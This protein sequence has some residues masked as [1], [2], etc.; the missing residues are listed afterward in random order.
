MSQ[1]HSSLHTT[2]L[3]PAITLLLDQHNETRTQFD[4]IET[5]LAALTSDPALLIRLQQAWQQCYQ[6]LLHH[7]A[8]EEYALFP[9]ISQY[10]PMV[11]M[12]IEHDDLL[13]MQHRLS[14]VL[15]AATP[16]TLDARMTAITGAWEAFSKQLMAHMV[17]EERGIFPLVTEFCEPEE[18]AMIER[19]LRE[20]N[21]QPLQRQLPVPEGVLT[22]NALHVGP[23]PH[24]TQAISLNALVD[25]EHVQVQQVFLK[26]GQ[27][28]KHH[29]AAEH[30]TLWVLSGELYVQVDGPIVNK[31][32][33]TVTDLSEASTAMLHQ[34]D[35]LSLAP[36]TWSQWT[37]LSDV[38]LMVVK[39]WPRPYFI[40][41]P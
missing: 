16:E 3:S 28:Y 40:R 18:Q 25:F 26:Q 20:L 29:W 14:D 33:S 5:L 8:L 12:T 7:Y 4:E 30:R 36:R 37:A 41:K 17:E 6:A 34:G 1:P 21:T 19:K 2:A 27:A 9:V 39:V 38:S 35:Q 32:G 24:L 10:R 13:V 31:A 11:L 23:L 15:Q 22:A